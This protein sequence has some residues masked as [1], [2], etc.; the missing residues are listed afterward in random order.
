[1][2][3]AINVPAVQLPNIDSVRTCRSH[4]E[5]F[6]EVP[7]KAFI[8]IP[9]SRLAHSQMHPHVLSFVLALC[10]PWYAAAFRLVTYNL[11]FDSMPNNITVQQ[12]LASLPD[13]LIQPNYLSLTAEQPWSLRRIRVA[14]HLISEGIILAGESIRSRLDTSCWFSWVR[15]LPGSADQTSPRYG[16]TTG[17]RLGL[18]ES[19]MGCFSCLTDRLLL[20]GWNWP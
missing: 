5:S 12:S 1:M 4:V 9:P 10:S 2:N 16:G 6:S 15:R 7:H 17:E 8:A 11:R 19:Q 13:P 20:L 18:G 3:L 14:E